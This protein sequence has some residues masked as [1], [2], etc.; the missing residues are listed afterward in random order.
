MGKQDPF[1]SR[2]EFWW[3]HSTEK[4]SLEKAFLSV[5]VLCSVVLK[6]AVN[7]VQFF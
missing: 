2:E 1:I 5:S 7:M 4:L 3:K 6:L